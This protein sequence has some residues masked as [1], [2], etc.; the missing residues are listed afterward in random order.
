MNIN[1]KAVLIT[2]LALTIAIS[3]YQVNRRIN[4]D[5]T[6]K[7]YDVA[8][9]YSDIDRISPIYGLKPEDLARQLANNGA[10]TILF[11]VDLAAKN[12]FVLPD[13]SDE[14]QEIGLTGGLEI[15]NLQLAG[16]D[17]V[18]LLVK[19]LNSLSARLVILRSLRAEVPTELEEWI[20]SND[21]ILA[22]VEFRDDLLTEKLHRITGANYVRLHRVFDKEVGTLSPEET[23]ARYVRAVKERNIGVIEY[24]LPPTRSISNSTSVLN[25]ITSQLKDVGYQRVEVESAKGGSSTL[26]SSEWIIFLLIATSITSL[27]ITL[28]IGYIPRIWL[29]I[30]LFFLILLLSLI[31]LLLFPVFLRQAAAFLLALG[32]PVATYRVLTKYGLSFQEGSHFLSP[33]VDFIGISIASTLIGLVISGILTDQIFMLKLDQFRGV[34]VS[35]F[36]PLLFIGL[37]YLFKLGFNIRNWRLGSFKWLIIGGF[38]G[39]LAFLL[40]RSGNFT[41][42]ESSEVEDAFRRWLEQ[43]LGVRPRFKEFILGHPAM[44]LWLYLINRYGSEVNFC[45]LGLALVGFIGQ[46]SIINTFAHI[47]SP[48]IISLTRTANGLAGGLLTGGLVLLVFLGGEKLWKLVNK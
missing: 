28:S 39:L 43:N 16:P 8:V 19:F 44:I 45:K 4:W 31:G 17:Q 14:L 7:E 26:N 20:R 3:L 42:L 40:L 35:L 37:L 47:H 24:R 48:L 11:Q 32:G 46:I 1:K 30:G 22:S 33:F 38:A 21:P 15:K 41:I 36:L 2:L 27:L 13:L 34:K 9:R 6:N 23:T 5:L 29:Q 10:N 25:E 12:K 18:D